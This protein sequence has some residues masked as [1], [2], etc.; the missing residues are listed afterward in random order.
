M[1]PKQKKLFV[2]FL[3]LSV[4]ISIFA[5]KTVIWDL[6]GVLFRPNKLKIAY[7]EIGIS[8]LWILCDLKLPIGLKDRFFS[9][10]NFHRLGTQKCAKTQYITDEEGRRLPQI[11]CE[12]LA[13]TKSPQD[14]LHEI[15]QL[16]DT[17]E[18][19]RQISKNEKVVMQK[20]AHSIFN[21]ETFAQYID[22]ISGGVQLLKECKKNGCRNIILSNWDPSSFTLLHGKFK[23]QLFSYVDDIIISGEC[24]FAKPQTKM[25]EFVKKNLGITSENKTDFIFI[26][27][28]RCNVLE[29]RKSGIRTIHLRNNNYMRIR[30]ILKK[31][32]FIK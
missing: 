2:I 29:A 7:H 23:N 31:L 20:I 24:G 3:L 1:N 15:N 8:P 25:Y 14:I 32:Q 6:G 18:A 4:H 16:L 9:L 19:T 22:P 27:D 28:Q 30:R 10:L 11:M 12:W 5:Q 13:G 21:P 26:D 17:Y